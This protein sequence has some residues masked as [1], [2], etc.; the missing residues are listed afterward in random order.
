MRREVPA[1]D[2]CA[3]ASFLLELRA[4]RRSSAVSSFTIANPFMFITSLPPATRTR[5]GIPRGRRPLE[6]F[7]R[8]DCSERNELRSLH[9]EWRTAGGQP[10]ERVRPP[11]RRGPSGPGPRAVGSARTPRRHPSRRCRAPPP[12]SGNRRRLPP[13]ARPSAAW[14]LPG[15]SRAAPRRRRSLGEQPPRTPPGRAGAERPRRPA[16]AS[17]LHGTRRTAGRRLG[18]PGRHRPRSA[19]RDGRAHPPRH[20]RRRRVRRGVPGH[21]EERRTPVLLGDLCDADEG[22]ELASPP[23]HDTPAAPPASTT[24]PAPASTRAPAGAPAPRRRE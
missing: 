21:L 1:L 17:P 24:E 2:A 13:P 4:E 16:L 7:V 5:S 3:P 6:R 11:R 15:G 8:Q 12:P 18:G 20:L 10:R 9:V 14:C 22:R 19:D 23:R